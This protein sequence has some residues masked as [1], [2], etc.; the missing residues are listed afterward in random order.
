MCKKIYTSIFLAISI[1]MLYPAYFILI[2]S[3]M[4]GNEVQEYLAPIMTN[5]DQYSTFLFLPNEFTPR[6]YV[7]LLLDTPGF[8]VLFWNS[9]K[10]TLLVVIGQLFVN[11][12]AAWAFA[13]YEFKLK[14][15]LSNLYMILMVMPFVVM[16]LPQY[17]VLR[18]LNLL[19][20]LFAIIFPAVFS[21]FSVFLIR[22][23]F[24]KI[25]K[26]MIEL[27]IIDGANDFKV[28]WFLGIPLAKPA[29]FTSIILNFIDYWA[30]IEQSLVF[31]ESKR[32]WT[33]PILLANIKMSNASVSFVAS[34]LTIIPPLLLMIYGKAYLEK[35]LSSI[36][37]K[38]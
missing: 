20:N 16:M 15:V 10:V 1:F 3:F 5:L 30:A 25:P 33:L 6:F 11:L 34:V 29:I 22:Y 28:F 23:Y 38:E 26:T 32:L 24:K 12:P 36:S 18:K 21:T 7:E 17:L 37:L 13:R 27:A 2:G 14:R 19:D 4:G 9:V 35:G 31:I 8:F